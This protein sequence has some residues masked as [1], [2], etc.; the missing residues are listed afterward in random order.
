MAT[1]ASAAGGIA[2]S[3][4]GIRTVEFTSRPTNL[5]AVKFETSTSLRTVLSH[6]IHY[7]L[8]DYTLLD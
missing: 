1:I 3:A 7:V 5:T 6:I 4:S 2:P 8:Q